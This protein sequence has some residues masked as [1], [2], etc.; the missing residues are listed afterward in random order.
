MSGKPF[1]RGPREALQPPR[2]LVLGWIG[3]WAGIF[4]R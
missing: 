1:A 2:R 3:M 4:E